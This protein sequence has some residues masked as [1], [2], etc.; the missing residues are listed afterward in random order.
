MEL[1]RATTLGTSTLCE[2]K[3]LKACCM[4]RFLGRA[5]VDEIPSDSKKRSFQDSKAG[6]VQHIGHQVPRTVDNSIM[7]CS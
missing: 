2:P 1:Y 4:I 3:N 5:T 7:Y 6:Q